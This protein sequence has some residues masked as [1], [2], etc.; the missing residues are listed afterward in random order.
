MKESAALPAKD[1]NIPKKIFKYINPIQK[2]PK[3][4]T[5]DV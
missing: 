4:A 3:K 5:K 2:A 1:Q